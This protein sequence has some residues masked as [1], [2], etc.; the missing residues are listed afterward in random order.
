MANAAL[1][2]R[3]ME[4][5]T[6]RLVAPNKGRFPRTRGATF[7]AFIRDALEVAAALY[8]LLRPQPAAERHERP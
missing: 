3:G 8:P 5:A 6:R 4:V 2:E 7:F 1:R